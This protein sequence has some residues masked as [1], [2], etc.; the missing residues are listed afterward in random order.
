MRNYKITYI[1]LFLA[2]VLSSCAQSEFS[3]S[4]TTSDTQ[5]VPVTLSLGTMDVETTRGT[6]TSDYYLVFVYKDGD[7]TKPEMVFKTTQAS[8]TTY[9]S[10]GKKNYY[11][12]RNYTNNTTLAAQLGT[13]SDWAAVPED[14]IQKLELSGSGTG[15]AVTEADTEVMVSKGTL[16]ID[17]GILTYSLAPLRRIGCQLLFKFRLRSTTF[18]DRTVTISKAVV[19]GAT[20]KTM[21]WRYD[22]NG[23][24]SETPLPSLTYAPAPAITVNASYP[25]DADF[26][27]YSFENIVPETGSTVPEGAPKV[28]FTIGI[29][30]DGGSITSHDVTGVLYSTSAGATYKNYY[31]LFRNHQ[32]T[33]YSE[34]NAAQLLG[35]ISAWNVLETLNVDAKER[36]IHSG[37]EFDAL[38]KYWNEHGLQNDANGDPDYSPYIEYGW[39]ENETVGTTTKKVF[40][41]K[42][43]EPFYLTGNTPLGNDTHP[44]TIPFDGQGWKISANA[45]CDESASSDPYG[46]LLIGHSMAEVSNVFIRSGAN[47]I[48]SA[49][50]DYVGNLAG[51]VEADITNCQ[52]LL[53]KAKIYSNTSNNTTYLGGL[54]GECTGTVSNSAVYDLT[55]NSYLETNKASDAVIGG[56]AGKANIKNSYSYIKGITTNAGTAAITAGWLV[57]DNTSS[58]DNAFYVYDSSHNNGLSNCTIVQKGEVHP[59]ADIANET[60]MNKLNYY[61]TS[62]SEDW[63][64]WSHIPSTESYIGIFSE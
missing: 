40:K 17:L 7:A 8:Y 50:Q 61:I 36:G 30:P 59:Y 45:D 33:V 41:F 58:V 23:T 35:S 53:S 4:E 64:S 1:L 63:P 15:D 49:Y 62:K 22:D 56:I 16:N 38:A 29:Q 6:S 44:L 2:L 57:G 54:V 25:S 47:L 48:T 51:K 32:Y 52:V 11:A 46:G 42:V 26:T 3:D 39:Y 37:T 5:K 28:T 9:L 21:L 24:F 12:F 19:N 55:S 43:A 27:L 31:S 60:I 10:T 34:I 13:S 18:T 14:K 20:N